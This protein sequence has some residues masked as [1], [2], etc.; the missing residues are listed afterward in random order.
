MAVFLRMRCLLA[1]AMWCAA[2]PVHAE[3]S[4]SDDLEDLDK[5]A[6]ILLVRNQQKMIENLSLQIQELNEQLKRTQEKLKDA[7]PPDENALGVQDEVRRKTQA[8][9]KAKPVGLLIV[10]KDRFTIK[11]PEGNDVDT[12]GVKAL[13]VNNTERTII[14][15]NLLVGCYN[16]HDERLIGLIVESRDRYLPGATRA[17]VGMA[18]YKENRPGDR[19]FIE[20]DI[21][22]MTFHV[23]LGA[24]QFENGEV[25]KFSEDAEEGRIPDGVEWEQ[26]GVE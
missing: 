18:F 19:E 12:L 1:L 7:K 10:Y 14:R 26:L 17:A 23:L 20:Q 8:A 6:L 22:D 21:E 4:D 11:D 2:I 25:F 24:I 3:Q 5:Q 9:L 13:L 16:R 15:T